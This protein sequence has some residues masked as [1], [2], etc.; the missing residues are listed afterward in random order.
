MTIVLLVAL[1]VAV[2]VPASLVVGYI[3]RASAAPELVGMDGTDAVFVDGDGQYARVPLL[4]TS[5]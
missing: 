3:L 5:P 1:W 2:S 4:T